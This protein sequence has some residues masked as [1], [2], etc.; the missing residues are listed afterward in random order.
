MFVDRVRELNFKNLKELKEPGDPAVLTAE[1]V[2]LSTD[3]E[4]QQ[5]GRPRASSLYDACMRMHVIGTKEIIEMKQYVSLKQRLTYGIGNAVHWWVQNKP[6]LF[7]D[8]RRG[9]W[10]CRACGTIIYFGPPPHMTCPYCGAKSE[11]IVYKEH[12]ISLWG[13]YPVTGH[14]DL[15]FERVS[16]VLT[17]AE[18]KTIDKDW[19][20]ELVAPLI[21]HEWQLNTYL[22]TCPQDGKLPQNIYP[23]KGYLIYI[24]KG[25][26][27]DQMPVKVFPVKASSKII[28]RIK[29]K[30]AAYKKGMDDYPASLPA[31]LDECVASSFGKYRAKTCP[32][33][34]ICQRLLER[35]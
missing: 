2:E 19:F 23:K 30:L 26:H 35:G 13:D 21:E 24:S 33:L 14:I 22:W 17:V 18:I 7:G 16:D 15:F 4:V 27:R 1:L 34:K 11:A 20:K 9:W 28:G 10:K 25:F 3:T 5:I 31:P 6:F 12:A 29:K 32:A 8:R